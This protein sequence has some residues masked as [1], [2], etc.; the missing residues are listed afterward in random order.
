[1]EE[2]EVEAFYEEQKQLLNDEYLEQLEKGT[3]KDR[4]EQDF[5]LK[6]NELNAKYNALM[7][8]ALKSK[9]KKNPIKEMEE[10]VLGKIHRL[11]GR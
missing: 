4:A 5:T 3:P 11:V 10:K 9:G 2:D 8:K 7:E 6:F 1:M